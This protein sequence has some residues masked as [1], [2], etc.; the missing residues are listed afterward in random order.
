MQFSHQITRKY[1]PHWPPLV[2]VRGTSQELLP[3]G[4]V[5]VSCVYHSPIGCPQDILKIPLEL[6]QCS[7]IVSL[8]G[9]SEAYWQCVSD[10]CC[11]IIGLWFQ[12]VKWSHLALLSY[13]ATLLP[14]Y[15]LSLVQLS[16]GRRIW[17]PIP[18]TN[19]LLVPN[20]AYL[21]TFCERN[22]QFKQSW[23]LW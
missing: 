16:M 8:I 12:E 22:K 14:W 3:F 11:T 18:E 7:D 20:W 5:P 17:M 13:H 10:C 15:D 9:R 21:K 19:K 1:A 23:R 2:G 6:F 4:V